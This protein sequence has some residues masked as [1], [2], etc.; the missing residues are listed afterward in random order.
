MTFKNDTDRLICEESWAETVELMQ[1][2]NIGPDVDAESK[3]HEIEVI[4][5]GLPVAQGG[6]DDQEV[7]F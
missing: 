5:A 2:F 6:E 3:Q 7:P 1:E 4:E